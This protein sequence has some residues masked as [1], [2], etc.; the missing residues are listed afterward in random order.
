MPISRHK[1]Q[2][3]HLIKCPC[4]LRSLALE[5]RPPRKVTRNRPRS[6]QSKMPTRVRDEQSNSSRDMEADLPLPHDS[7]ATFCLLHQL[8]VK[9][10]PMRHW[11]SNP[12]TIGWWATTP[13]TNNY[14]PRATTSILLYCLKSPITFLGAL[15]RG[16]PIT[17][18]PMNLL[19]DPDQHLLNQGLSQAE[20]L[21]PNAT[22]PSKPKVTKY[23]LLM[24]ETNP[25]C[26]PRNH[27]CKLTGRLVWDPAMRG[28]PK[29]LVP[30]PLP[31]L[32][33]KQTELV[34]PNIRSKIMAFPPSIVLKWMSRRRVRDNSR[35]PGPSEAALYVK[36]L[37]PLR[38]LIHLP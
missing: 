23:N 5:A 13:R 19:Q 4:I 34:D 31:S 36:S 29:R 20:I 38:V 14:K 1:K 25:I 10:L 6:K 21:S 16:T 18:P 27:E 8:L 2:T 12:K 15:A 28:S 17:T 11:I 22:W 9:I 26:L 3:R 35:A 33:V 7:M 30:E 37:T 32:E 24:S